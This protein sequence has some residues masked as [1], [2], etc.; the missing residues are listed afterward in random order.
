[1]FLLVREGLSRSSQAVILCSTWAGVFWRSLC[2]CGTDASGSL[3]LWCVCVRSCLGPVHVE[4]RGLE[5]G[6]GWGSLS[7]ALPFS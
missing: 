6:A 7:E 1:M 5:R 4:G 3:A 2:V